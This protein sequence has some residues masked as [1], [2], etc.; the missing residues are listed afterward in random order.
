MNTSRFIR[1]FWVKSFVIK[2]NKRKRLG[3]L[4]IKNIILY[5]FFMCKK[6]Y[7]SNASKKIKIDS[8]GFLILD[9][10]LLRNILVFL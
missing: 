3:E 10:I 5:M 7:I 2:K 8:Y 1:R 9:F 4:N 6:I